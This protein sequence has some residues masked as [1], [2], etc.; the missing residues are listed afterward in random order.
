MKDGRIFTVRVLLRSLG[1]RALGEP[2]GSVLESAV[3]ERFMIPREWM[4]RKGR[5]TEAFR[6]TWRY[7]KGRDEPRRHKTATC[8]STTRAS[9][10]DRW[11]NLRERCLRGNKRPNRICHIIPVDERNCIYRVLT[12]VETE[13]LN[14]FDDNWTRD[15]PEKWRYFCMGNALVVGLVSQMGL[16][17]KYVIKKAG[18]GRKKTD[19]RRSAGPIIGPLDID[20]EARMSRVKCE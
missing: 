8:T 4:G 19:I 3:D 11:T 7:C 12:P 5:G 17:L 6:R 2:L 18:A 20:Y 9:P 10:P 1:T 16:R 14:G 15:M 13:R